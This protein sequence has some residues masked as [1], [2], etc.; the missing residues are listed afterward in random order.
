MDEQVLI[1]YK[2]W[3]DSISSEERYHFNEDGAG[4][5]KDA[6]QAL[7]KLGE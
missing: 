2:T 5:I 3:K 7:E 6:K 4:Y 1:A